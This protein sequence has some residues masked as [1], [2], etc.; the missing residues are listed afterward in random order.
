MLV[1]LWKLIVVLVFFHSVSIC[2]CHHSNSVAR[3]W[4]RVS[5]IRGRRFSINHS[6][7][8]RINHSFI[9]INCRWSLGTSC[10][11]VLASKGSIIQIAVWELVVLST[12]SHWL[13]TRRYFTWI[14]TL[15]LRI[16]CILAHILLIQTLNLLRSQF[17][18]SFLHSAPDRSIVAVNL[19][20]GLLVGVRLI[21]LL[22]EGRL[23]SITL[24]TYIPY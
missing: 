14:C 15:P 24:D 7:L 5:V 21:L 19:V 13:S 16:V 6:S 1:W 20:W 10:F 3:S 12:R 9:V 2:G 11:I 17:T 8:E 4:L 23:K 22:H 18:I